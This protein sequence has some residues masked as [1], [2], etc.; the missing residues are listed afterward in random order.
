MRKVLQMMKKS[1]QKIFQLIDI[2]GEMNDL[3]IYDVEFKSSLLKIY[4]NNKTDSINLQTCEKFM[5]SLIFLFQS[6]GIESI[7]CEVSSPG[8]ERNLRKDWHYISAV[9]KTVKIY[10]KKPVI[11][12]D[13][14]SEKEKQTTILYGQLC[15]YKDNTINVKDGFLNWTIPLNIIKKAHTVFKNTK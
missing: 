5:K 12:Y 10:T 14:K 7:D 11:C 1:I 9:G 6:E 3:Y 2:A 8:L 13:K 4:I 15:D